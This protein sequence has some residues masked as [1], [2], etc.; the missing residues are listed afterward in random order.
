M[1]LLNVLVR[2]FHVGFVA[3]FVCGVGDYLQPTVGQ[4]DP[5]F[6]FCRLRVLGLTV[7]EVVAGTTIEDLVRELVEFT[8]LLR[9]RQKK[10]V[11]IE[12]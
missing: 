10:I 3:V 7:G 2:V 6:A 11:L 8:A 12:V 1:R 4:F 9:K 5:I